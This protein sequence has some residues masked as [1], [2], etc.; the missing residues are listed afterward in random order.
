MAGHP[1]SS[2]PID[3]SPAR[4]GKFHDGSDLNADAVVWNFEKILRQE[5]PQ[6]DERQA[7]QDKGRVPTV[8][9]VKAIDPLTV[10]ITTY[11]L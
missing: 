11:A 4:R 7:P 2:D 9:D 3:V 1:G 8:V 5:A 6:F 10:D